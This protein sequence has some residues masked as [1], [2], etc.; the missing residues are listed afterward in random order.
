MTFTRA[1]PSGWTADVDVWTAFQANKIDTNMANA[2]DGANGGTYAGDITW[3]GAHTFSGTETHSNTESHSG[4]NTFTDKIILSGTG[5]GIRI[6]AGTFTNA[7]ATVDTS[8]DVYVAQAAATS[9]RTIT[10]NDTGGTVPEEG[11]VISFVSHISGGVSYWIFKRET[12]AVELGRLG[13]NTSTEHGAGLGS[14]SF[15]YTG[16]AWIG[17][18][19]GGDAKFTAH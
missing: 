15:I 19:V 10:L 4:E 3:S 6:R 16:G 12:A 11:D 17:R 13:T 1:K 7:D 8:K 2:V 18:K 9:P 14:I 5:A